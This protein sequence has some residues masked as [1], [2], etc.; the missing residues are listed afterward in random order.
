[1]R[2]KYVILLY[3]IVAHDALCYTALDFELVAECWIISDQV[4]FLTLEAWSV[5]EYWDGI[6]VKS[7]G[8][9]KILN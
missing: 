6:E 8:S 7:S 9:L 4:A 1:M 3:V 2:C 5:L